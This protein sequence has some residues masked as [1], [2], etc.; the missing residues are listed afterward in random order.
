M[1]KICP[2]CKKEK[3]LELGFSKCRRCK[4]GYASYCKKCVRELQYKWE[5]ENKQHRIEY[6]KKWRQGDKF[7][8]WSS[9]WNQ[10]PRRKKHNKKRYK[11]YYQT[12]KGHAVINLIKAKRREKKR[13]LI[14]DLTANQVLELLQEQNN[15]CKICQKNFSENL[16]YTLDHI[17]PVSLSK[18]GDPGLTKSN[19]QLLCA[20]CNRRKSNKI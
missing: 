18:P 7:K 13:Q 20:I 6:Q 16:P 17:F 12:P 14:N 10:T 2:C 9:R 19:V 3:D 8:E 11:K 1:T 15:K 5:K 4:S